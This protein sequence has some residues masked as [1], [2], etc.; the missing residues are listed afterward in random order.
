MDETVKI[1]T[2]VKHFDNLDDFGIKK[3]EEK[4]EPKPKLNL[5]KSNGKHSGLNNS[6]WKFIWFD[7]ETLKQ[8]INEKAAEVHELRRGR[9][10]DP[11][12][13]LQRRDQD[14]RRG[15]APEV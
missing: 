8:T 7:K 14:Q 1:Y 10:E 3:K 2:P 4:S 15:P 13:D 6:K 11:Q 9:L 5:R 12:R